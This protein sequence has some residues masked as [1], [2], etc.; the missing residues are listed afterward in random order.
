VEIRV[1]EQAVSQLCFM[2]P[3][4]HRYP[5]NLNMTNLLPAKPAK[6]LNYSFT[7]NLIRI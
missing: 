4:N 7:Q 1:S 5:V 6:N 3:F 2:L